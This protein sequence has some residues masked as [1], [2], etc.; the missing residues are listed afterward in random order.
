MRKG[1]APVAPRSQHYG[2]HRSYVLHHRTPVARGG[3]RYDPD[4]I[5]VV[6]PRYHQEVLD[7]SYHFGNSG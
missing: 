4:N 7:G 5:M 3:S 2:K 1:L 6:S